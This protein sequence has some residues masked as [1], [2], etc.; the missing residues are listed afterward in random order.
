[1]SGLSMGKSCFIFK[2]KFNTITKLLL[3][4]FL[5][6]AI[7]LSFDLFLW[8]TDT[9]I[10]PIFFI[11]NNLKCVVMTSLDWIFDTVL[12]C[13]ALFLQLSFRLYLKYAK[14]MNESNDLITIKL[15]LSVMFA[16]IFV[17]IFPLPID[18]QTD[19][20]TILILLIYS[21]SPTL[22][23]FDHP[24]FNQFFMES[25]PLVQAATLAVWHLMVQFYFKCKDISSNFWYAIQEN[26]LNF[27]RSNQ[28][29]PY[30]VFE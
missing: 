21:I 7:V 12:S 29:Q 19:P 13:T 9:T 18:G 22:I 25:H 17:T 16:Y 24:G 28:V 2:L 27:C 11:E 20:Y 3:S 4:R 5:S 8:S 10:Y 6:I 26:V 1:M 14:K 23:L 15:L 30:P